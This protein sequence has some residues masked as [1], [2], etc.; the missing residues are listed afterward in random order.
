MSRPL[1]V[2]F[3]AAVPVDRAAGFV[4]RGYFTNHRAWDRGLAELIA[5]DDGP[6]A[7]GTRGR[8][9][10]SFFGRTETGFEVVEATDRR[11]HLQDEPS[12]W[13]LERTYELTPI[14]SDTRSRRAPGSP[15]RST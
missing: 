13:A 5:E 14:P 12:R 4:I 10:R 3:E 6:V 2:T 8:E 11:L 1:E 9:V 7:P 15:S